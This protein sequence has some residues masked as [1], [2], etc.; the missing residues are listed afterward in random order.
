MSFK[1]TYK[2]FGRSAILITWEAKIDSDI[3]K[4]ITLF[5]QKIIEN[6][7]DKIVDVIIGYHSIAVKYN[8]D[9]NSL[10]D[11]IQGLEIIYKSSINLKQVENFIWEIPVCYDEVFGFDLQIISE[12]NKIEISEIIKL[13]AQQIYTVYF[14]GFLPGF[15]YLGGLN[16]QLHMPRKETPRLKVACGSVAIGAQQTGVYPAES[17][18]GWNIIGKTPVSFFDVHKENPCFAKAGD[19]IRFMPISKETFYHFEEKGC[20]LKKNILR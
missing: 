1:K 17:A 15:L 3:L 12:R 20:V 8:E 16:K 9:I 19:C 5:K 10:V 13:H 6:I 7:S 11:E 14:I 18:G 4:D 2:L